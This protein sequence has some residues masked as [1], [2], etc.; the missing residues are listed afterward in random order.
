MT[1]A[2]L[3]NALRAALTRGGVENPAGDARCILGELLG[4]SRIDLITRGDTEVS[5]Q[6]AEQ[7]MEMARR[8]ISGEPIQYIIGSW[9]FMGRTYR[10]GKGVL[11]PRDDTEVVVNAV[12]DRMKGVMRPAVVDLCAGSGIIA[13]TLFHA[14]D[15]STVYAVEKSD[16]AF[17]YL[18]ENAAL[19]KADIELIHADLRDCTE[20]FPENSLDLIVSNPPY[21]KSDEIASLQSEVQHEPRLALDGGESGYDF[22]QL[23]LDRWTAKLK[24]GGVIAFE[25]GEDQFD[26]VAGLLRER[27]YTDIVGCFDIGGVI[28]AVTAVLSEPWPLSHT[29]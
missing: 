24:A 25:L 20:R 7:A 27:G 26:T 3:H 1:A 16:D 13:I 28:R 12:I 2:A 10:V 4:F 29:R 14:L 22:Y 21:I 19:N 9:S 8:R 23:I 17:G 5:D 6:I 15:H 18:C 11:I